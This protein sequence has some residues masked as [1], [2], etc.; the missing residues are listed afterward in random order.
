MFASLVAACGGG[1]ET[2]TEDSA[3][4]KGT[5]N[6]IVIDGSNTAVIGD[7]LVM[8]G[9]QSV[10][11]DADGRFTLSAV[12]VTSRTVLKVNAAGFAEG[13][14]VTQ[15]KEG[16]TSQ[17][18]IQLTRVLSSA[19]VNSSTGGTVTVPG[20]TA[21]VVLPANAIVTSS[22]AVYD[23]V[24]KV[25]VTPIAPAVD[26][27]A[28]PGGY[29]V[30]TASGT[31]YMESWG[32]LNVTLSDANGQ[33]LNLAP[34]K[35]ASIRIPVS[36]RSVTK[37]STIDLFY[38]N[39]TTGYWVKE[40]SATLSV[41]GLYYEGVVSHFTVWNADRVMDTVYVE[42]CVVDAANVRVSNVLVKSDGRDYSG[43]A[44][45][46]TNADGVF[47]LPIKRQGA[48]LVSGTQLNGTRVLLTNTLVAGPDSADIDLTNTCLTLAEQTDA[49]SIKLTWGLLPSDV[50]GHLFAPDGEHIYYSNPGS[51][52]RQPFANLDVDDISGFGPEVITVTRLMVGTY[53][54]ALHNFTGSLSPGMAA[55]PVRVELTRNART[56]VQAFAPSDGD[57]NN[58]WWTAFT[59]TVDA[60]CNTTVTPVNTWGTVVPVFTSATSVPVYC[61]RP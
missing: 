43:A 46:M 7:A 55:S 54:Y 20:S 3:G 39:N 41:D 38:F 5:I 15:V 25:S 53:T 1:Q 14:Q 61:Q 49:V 37:P 59:M 40:G 57:G 44:T 21:R 31:V 35:T 6:G 17:V 2:K 16:E 11:T 50:D 18:E 51:L 9:G 10:R 24:V 42:G 48:A 19:E 8:V 30:A 47:R 36:T 12:S 58:M 45:A 27:N 23:G 4:A 29:Q 52:T 28:M 33:S 56:L 34:N 60:Q 26:V 13:F 22:G 32:A